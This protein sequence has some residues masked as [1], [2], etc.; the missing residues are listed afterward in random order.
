VPG[1]WEA[2]AAEDDLRA[3][4]PGAAGL[5]RTP[6]VLVVGGGVVGLATAVMCRRAGLE[7]VA[8]IERERLAGAASGSAAGGL[9]PGVHA[10]ARPES[11]AEL[12]CE[13]LAL[14][15]QLDAEWEGAIGLRALDWVLASA[16]PVAPGPGPIS[17]SELVDAE[18]ACAVEPSL[19]EV[20]GALVIRDQAWAHPLRLAAALA[21]RAGAVAT[22]V[23]MD[24]LVT[25]G[26]R[27]VRVETSAGSISPGAV[28]VATGTAPPELAP[29]EWSPV[30]GHLIATAPGPV[31]L[32]AAVASS[33]LVLPLAGGGLLAGGTME[34][35]DRDPV[36]RPETVSTITD[37]LARLLPAASGVAVEHAW[38]CF[39]PA[40]PDQLP[41]I[42]HVL[43]VSN[44][45]LNT[46]H[47][48][49]GLLVAPAAGRALADWIATGRR[50]PVLA[51]L[52]AGRFG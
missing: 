42:D 45:W 26:G 27:V 50:P 9:S 51:S 13:G 35:D 25:A 38:C 7:R 22:G 49:T 11:F 18:G 1:V 20:G 30:K 24:R 3:L 4:A 40:A 16:E 34:P 23:A 48:R 29:I 10:M 36:V 2:T 43:G 5:D 41:V 39:R 44:A 46:G 31:R 47:F 15:R 37:E 33:I 14:H 19:G 17:G 28:V 6:D 12:A 32:R 21:R 52:G 8:V